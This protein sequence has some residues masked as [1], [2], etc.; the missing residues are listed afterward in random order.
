MNELEKIKLECESDNFIL[1]KLYAKTMKYDYKYRIEVNDGI[2]NK[3]NEFLKRDLEKLNKNEYLNKLI[4]EYFYY[5]ERCD[6]ICKEIYYRTE[7]FEGK[8]MQDF[9]NE[10]WSLFA[11]KI[12]RYKKEYNKFIKI[13]GE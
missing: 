8:T 6:D 1:E 13:K 9:K 7:L 10:L 5:L 11:G 4:N 12:G 2:I 3:C